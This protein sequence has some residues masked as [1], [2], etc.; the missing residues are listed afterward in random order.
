VVVVAIEY[1]KTE[2]IVFCIATIE[3]AGA[4]EDAEEEG[5]ELP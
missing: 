1:P 4:V 5:V 2:S 3:A